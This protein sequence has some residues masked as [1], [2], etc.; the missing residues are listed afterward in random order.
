MTSW[1]HWQHKG[2]IC[3]TDKQI[4]R[5]E[6][7]ALMIMVH[8]TWTRGSPCF[9]VLRMASVSSS[10]AVY[11]QAHHHKH[12]TSD[13]RYELIMV[14]KI[15]VW[16]CASAGTIWNYSPHRRVTLSTTCIGKKAKRPILGRLKILVQGQPKT[17]PESNY[18]P[19]NPPKANH[20]RSV[21]SFK[22]ELDATHQ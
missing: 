20:S 16:G 14:K 6:E 1:C 4:Y 22:T 19:S 7:K 3:W 10:S 13:K 21:R 5:P 12:E 2:W 11:H 9:R 15:S 8:G 18:L 17:R